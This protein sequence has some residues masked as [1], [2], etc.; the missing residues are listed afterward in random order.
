MECFAVAAVVALVAGTV[1]VAGYSSKSNDDAQVAA[2]AKCAACPARGTEACCKAGGEGCGQCAATGAGA[3]GES[4][5][6]AGQAKP[7]CQS[8]SQT[9]GAQEAGSAAC[10]GQPTCA[11][12]KQPASGSGQCT[13][14][15]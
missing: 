13:L 15:K 6:G 1:L 7:A 5:C 10:C 12:P 3:C 4:A 14:A 11:Q 9:C 8:G 2:D